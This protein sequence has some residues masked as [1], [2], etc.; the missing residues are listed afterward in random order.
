VKLVPEE[1]AIQREWLRTKANSMKE[2]L[3]KFNGM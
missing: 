3:Q 1:L 2:E